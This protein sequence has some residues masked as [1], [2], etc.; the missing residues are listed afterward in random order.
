MSRRRQQQLKK[1]R[2]FVSRAA[3]GVSLIGLLLLVLLL[4]V[5]DTTPTLI[6][7]E[8]AV[9]DPPLREKFIE[10]ILK[11]YPPPPEVKL[12]Q[13]ATPEVL[14]ELEHIH[15][16]VPKHNT[17]MTTNPLEAIN[18][19]EIGSRELPVRISVFPA[20]FNALYVQNERD[21]IASLLHEYDHVRYLNQTEVAGF[22][23]KEDFLVVGGKDEGQYHLTL[24]NIVHELNA[25][26]AEIHRVTSPDWG[27]SKLYFEKRHEIY[28]AEYLR[29]LDY[30]ENGLPV[31]AQVVKRAK[32]EFFAPWFPNTLM[33]SLTSDGTPKF[34]HPDTRKSYILPREV[35]FPQK[36]Q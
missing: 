26:R 13:Y 28:V 27:S 17:L 10:R 31:R 11:Q 32:I 29:L 9:A 22:S 33:F 34:T 24:I 12:V 2:R 6:T 20:V 25:F 1:Q 8:R 7:F 23:Y 36:S 18:V 14:E 16:F 3:A 15:S 4:V 30:F 19:P 35:L 5:R 21:F